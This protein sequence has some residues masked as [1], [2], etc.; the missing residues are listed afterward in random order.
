MAPYE[1]V[2]VPERASGLF[3]VSSDGERFMTAAGFADAPAAQ[4]RVI[5]NPG[6]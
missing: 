4:L 5:V 1:V 6:G 3:I 2:A